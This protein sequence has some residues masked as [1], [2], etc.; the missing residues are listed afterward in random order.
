MEKFGVDESTHHNQE[1]LEKKAAEGCPV[2]GRKVIVSGSVIRCP[3]HGT[4]PFEKPPEESP[5]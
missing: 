3:V 1:E 2:C 5:G 4:E